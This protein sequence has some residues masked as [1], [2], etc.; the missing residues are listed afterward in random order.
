MTLS[1]FAKRVVGTPFQGDNP[2]WGL[3]QAAFNDCFG[4]DLPLG[5]D[6]S[7]K[8]P[9]DASVALLEGCKNWME[10]QL[11]KE[12]PGDGILIR[13][14]H[15]AIVLRRGWMLNCREGVGTV[16]ERY[17]CRLWRNSILGIYRHADLVA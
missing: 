5:A 17:D 1:E 2:C 10:V 16:I 13:P 4:I 6:Y 14:C 3:F 15:V 12:Q 7:Y 8:N 9:R 11:G